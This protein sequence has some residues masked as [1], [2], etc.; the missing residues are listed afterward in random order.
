MS[1]RSAITAVALVVTVAACSKTGGPAARQADQQ[2][3]AGV[4]QSATDI[5]EY[6]SDG[7]LVKLGHASCDAFAA[8]ANLQQIAGLLEGGS[9]RGLPPSDVGAVMASA[10]KVL[11]PGYAGR[12][13]PVPSGG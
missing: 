7:Q 3:V 12:I 1:A 4:H 5:G 9:G 8:N 11:C 10:V 2:F 6:R 13:T